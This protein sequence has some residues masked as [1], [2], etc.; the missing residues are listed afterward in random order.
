MFERALEPRRI[1]GP[2]KKIGVSR[3]RIGRALRAL[4]RTEEA[5]ALQEELLSTLPEDG[6]VSEE[7]GECLLALGR[8]DESR[9][10]F[11]RAADLLA[12]DSWLVMQEPERLARLRK[13]GGAVVEG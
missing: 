8:E 7:M 10:H 5:L 3:W 11:R 1:D 4:G 6:Y 9:P 13:L 12:R 2:E